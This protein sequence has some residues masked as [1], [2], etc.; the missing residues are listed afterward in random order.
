MRGCAAH[1]LQMRIVRI[2]AARKPSRHPDGTPATAC[3]LRRGGIGGCV[4]AR[5]GPDPA[6]KP[7]SASPSQS[8]NVEIRSGIADRF[9]VPIEPTAAVLGLALFAARRDGAVSEM[10]DVLELVPVVG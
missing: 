1:S 9:D 10:A 4:R 7:Y 6:E 2:R 3:R 5:T 8:A